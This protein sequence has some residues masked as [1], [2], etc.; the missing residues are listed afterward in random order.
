LSLFLKRKQNFAKALPTICCFF[1]KNEL[2]NQE[3]EA[4]FRVWNPYRSKLGASIINGIKEIPIKPGEKV[5]YLGAASGT[6]V[7]H[8]SD[9]V[10]PV[11]KFFFFADFPKWFL[12]SFYKKLCFRLCVVVVVFFVDSYCIYSPASACV[13]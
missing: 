6:T 5:L 1:L 3:N 12:E 2:R 7:S 9:I 10:G 4:M 13:G 11:I 8:V